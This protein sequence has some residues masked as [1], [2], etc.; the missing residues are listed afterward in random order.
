MSRSAWS[1]KPVVWG[2]GALAALGLM[3]GAIWLADIDQLAALFQA[4]FGLLQGWDRRTVLG[5]VRPAGWPSRAGLEVRPVSIVAGGLGWRAESIK[6][7]TGLRW[8]GMSVG[9][10]DVQPT[11]QRVRFGSGME[12]VVT[13]RSLIIEVMDDGTALRSMELEVA[14]LFKLQALRLWLGPSGLTVKAGHL[15]LFGVAGTPGPII[16]TLELHA[17]LTPPLRFLGNTQL[18]ATA[19]Q[20]A[21]GVMELSEFT[22][23]TGNTRVSGSAKAR[24]DAALQPRLDGVVHVIGYAA[25]LDD[26]VTAGFLA[27]QTAIAA[28]AVLGLLAAPSADGGADIPV[29]I[30]D[31][32]LTIAQFPLLRLPELEWS[33]PVSG[34]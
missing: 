12:R 33:A 19:W 13:S 1:W 7:S 9:P 17:A 8:P 15:S 3:H 25:G 27:T 11:D 4:P 14:G 31:G 29:Q 30:A 20:T 21:A 32:I 22:L 18:S 28:K 10:I 6:A 34:P 2:Y 5:Q 16:D 26:L 23:A 24:L